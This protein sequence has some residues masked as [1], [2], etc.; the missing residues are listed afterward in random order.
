MQEESGRKQ[1]EQITTHAVQPT[2]AQ[3]DGPQSS[4][5]A[6]ARVVQQA[7]LEPTA[8]GRIVF[9]DETVSRDRRGVP[10]DWNDAFQFPSFAAQHHVHVTEHI[11]DNPREWLSPAQLGRLYGDPEARK[12]LLKVLAEVVYA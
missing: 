12:V 7:V 3:T 6:A 8:P 11:P 1:P 4:H 9:I 2:A 10:G 5:T